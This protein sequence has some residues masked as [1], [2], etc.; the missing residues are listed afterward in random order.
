MDE[1]KDTT[2]YNVQRLKENAEYMFRI[3]AEN[4]V[5]ISEYLESEPVTVKCKYCKYPL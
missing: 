3:S 1:V 2:V 5:G 4:S